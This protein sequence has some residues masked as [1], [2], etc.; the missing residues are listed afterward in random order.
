MSAEQLD[1]F[2]DA[3]IAIEYGWLASEADVAATH[4]IQIVTAAEEPDRQER[5]A[6]YLRDAFAKVAEHTAGHHDG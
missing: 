1:L 6:A 3:L 4:I 5:V 2:A